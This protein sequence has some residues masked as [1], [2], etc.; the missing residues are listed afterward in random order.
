MGVQARLKLDGGLGSNV[1]TIHSKAHRYCKSLLASS[2][3]RKNRRGVQGVGVQTSSKNDSWSFSGAR[4]TWCVL[5]YRCVS[6]VQEMARILLWSNI[7]KPWS[8]ES[9]WGHLVPDIPQEYLHFFAERVQKLP[10]QRRTEGKCSIQSARL[11]DLASFTVT[12]R[13]RGLHSTIFDG[14]ASRDG[15]DWPHS[16]NK[17]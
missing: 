17:P 10:P 3:V 5:L 2:Q 12:L 9:G 1:G 13:G 15:Q 4:R 8:A 16:G 14:S 7:R 11:S 6:V